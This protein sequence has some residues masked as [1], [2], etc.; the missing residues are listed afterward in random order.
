MSGLHERTYIDKARG[1]QEVVEQQTLVPIQGEVDRL[2][3]A[4]DT[5]TAVE[6]LED[7]KP[8][9]HISRDSLND[10]VVWNPGPQAAA[11]MSD[12]GPSDGWKRMRLSFPFRESPFLSCFLLVMFIYI[13]VEGRGEGCG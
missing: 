13:I 7:G 2:Y 10:V 8:R 3:K 4:V 11:K 5:Q 12:F 6:V 9:F 1:Y